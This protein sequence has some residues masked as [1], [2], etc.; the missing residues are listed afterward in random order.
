MGKGTFDELAK[1]GVDFSSLL[2]RDEEEEKI[3]ET[4]SV[5]FNIQPRSATAL[6]CKISPFSPS[7]TLVFLPGELRYIYVNR[8]KIKSVYSDI[9]LD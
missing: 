5:A 4:E 3:M 9:K 7:L 2:K 1:S 8:P 6:R